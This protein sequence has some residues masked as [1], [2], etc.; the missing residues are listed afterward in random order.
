MLNRTTEF[1]FPEGIM[2]ERPCEL[3][4][5]VQCNVDQHSFKGYMHRAL[6]TVAMV[7][8][9]TKSDVL[10]VLRSSTEGA[11]KSCLSDGT[12]GFRWDRGSYDGDVDHGPAG[13]QMS[14]LAALTTLLLDVRNAPPLTN[15]TG[16]TS[17][18][19]PNAGGNPNVLLPPPP[20]TPAWRGG[21]GVLTAIVL[22]SMIG[23][24]FWMSGEW[25]ES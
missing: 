4:D 21:A 15:R 11:V 18:G 13:Q 17:L 25:S 16:G 14:A 9:F 3:E 1:F 6:A 2:V 24:L 10:K 20:V 22:G 19:D 8:P 12:C 23:G 7:A 5:K